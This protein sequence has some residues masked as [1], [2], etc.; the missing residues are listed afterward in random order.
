LKKGYSQGQIASKVGVTA[1]TVNHW[2]TGRSL[3]AHPESIER[4]KKFL[5]A[6]V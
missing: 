4:L 2:W 6:H 1:I 5:S 3:M